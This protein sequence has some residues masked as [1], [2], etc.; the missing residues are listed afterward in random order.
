[1]ALLDIPPD[2]RA[3][4]GSTVERITEKA[5]PCPRCGGK[6]VCSIHTM[7]TWIRCRECGYIVTGETADE[8]VKKWNVDDTE[9]QSCKISP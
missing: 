1:M 3:E 7:I 6:P 8:A 9:C 4:G 2:R 5:R